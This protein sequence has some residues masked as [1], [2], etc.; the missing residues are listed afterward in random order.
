MTNWKVPDTVASACLATAGLGTTMNA[1]H[2]AVP[3][4]GDDPVD[5]RLLLRARRVDKRFSNRRS[6]V[7]RVS[8]TM[9]AVEAVLWMARPHPST[10]LHP[11]LSPCLQR[12]PTPA[13][14][15][16][17]R[18]GARSQAD[19]GRRTHL[20]ALRTSKRAG[21]SRPPSSMAKSNS[22]RDRGGSRADIVFSRQEW[23]DYQYWVQ[24]DRAVA[25]RIV[26]LIEE[27]LRHPFRGAGNPE[28]PSSMSCPAGGRAGSRRN[29]ASGTGSR[30]VGASSLSAATTN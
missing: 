23:E 8:G 13:D 19:H 9:P 26:R 21:W 5:H 6:M 11:P 16:G 7:R 30:A 1:T 20:V 17:A 3:A 29:T 18:H 2:G 22:E 12:R 15:A 28:N 25:R 4:G 27:C 14:G 10:R 24:N